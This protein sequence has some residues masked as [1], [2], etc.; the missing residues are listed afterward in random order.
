MYASL[1]SSGI[2]VLGQPANG[3]LQYSLSP[4]VRGKYGEIDE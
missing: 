3:G 2:T 1:T 4:G